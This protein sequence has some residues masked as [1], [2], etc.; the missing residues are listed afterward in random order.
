[1]VLGVVGDE[2]R[3]GW[4]YSSVSCLDYSVRLCEVQNLFAKA[5]MMPEPLGQ[6]GRVTCHIKLSLIY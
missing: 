3:R 5:R 4:M 6:R 2:P 1:M